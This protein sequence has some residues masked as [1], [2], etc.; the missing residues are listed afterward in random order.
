MNACMRIRIHLLIPDAV[1]ASNTMPEQ[2]QNNTRTIHTVMSI[3][4]ERNCKTL[5]LRN[6]W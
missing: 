4:V 5:L 6:T 1:S 2:C 3:D